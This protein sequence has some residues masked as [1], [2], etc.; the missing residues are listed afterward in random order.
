MPPDPERRQG[1]IMGTATHPFDISTIEVRPDALIDIRWRQLDGSPGPKVGQLE[2]VG[3]GYRIRY[4]HGA[5]YLKP[6]PTNT[7]AW[8]Y[9]AIGERYDAL[10][11][12]A[13]WLGFPVADEAEFTDGGRISRFEHGN[14]YWWPDV[15]AIELNEVVVRYTGLICFGETDW[16]QGSFEDEPYAVIGTV[17]PMGTASY[18]SRIYEDVDAG[19]GVS[20]EMEI[21]RGQ[22]LGL[23]IATLLMEHDASDPDKYKEAVK[24]GVDAAAAGATAAVAVIPGVGPILAAGLGPALGALAPTITEVINETLDLK[25]DTLGL[26]TIT[27]TPKQMVVLAARTENSVSH[28][29][30]FKVETPLFSRLGASYKVCFSLAALQP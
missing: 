2:T 10:G 11:G 21:Y 4:R 30:T 27:M 28:G 24:I 29:V 20:D 8:V 17:T 16:D 12:P 15:G 5:I 22:A 13:S 14:I 26:Q 7:L 1:D 19:E 25:D 18:R 6:G 3:S 23:V 9:G